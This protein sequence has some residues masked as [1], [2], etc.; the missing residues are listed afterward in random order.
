MGFT[1]LCVGEGAPHVV[2]RLGY[3]ADTADKGGVCVDPPVLHLR[4]DVLGPLKDVILLGVQDHQVMAVCWG[5]K[6]R[7]NK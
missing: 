5:N 4:L 2:L 3:E 6:Y 1:Y 7:V